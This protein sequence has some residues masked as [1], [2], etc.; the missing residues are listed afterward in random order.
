[1]Q[2]RRVIGSHLAVVI[3]NWVQSPE[4]PDGTCSREEGE[5]NAGATEV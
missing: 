3:F 4:E 1:M 2:G 5:H